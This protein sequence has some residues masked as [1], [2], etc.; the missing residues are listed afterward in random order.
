[1]TEHQDGVGAAVM[2]VLIAWVGWVG[3]M[4]LSEWVLLATLIYTVL[5]IYFLIKNKGKR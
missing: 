2:K 4:Q 5:Q 1:M 3:G